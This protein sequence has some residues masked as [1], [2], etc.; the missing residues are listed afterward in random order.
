MPSRDG[1]VTWISA[2]LVPDWL[3]HTQLSHVFIYETTLVED[4][5]EILVGTVEYWIEMKEVLFGFTYRLLR[6]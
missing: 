6:Q 1:M 2:E 4:G 3:K 5:T